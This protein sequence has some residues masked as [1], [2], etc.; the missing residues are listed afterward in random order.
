MCVCVLTKQFQGISENA[1]N[2]NSLGVYYCNSHR[3]QTNLGLQTMPQQTNLAQISI[4]HEYD[5]SKEQFMIY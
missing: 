1:W 3:H 5:Y 4:W 2:F